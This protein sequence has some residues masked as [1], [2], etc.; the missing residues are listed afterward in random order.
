MWQDGDLLSISMASA[1]ASD[2]RVVGSSMEE[3]FLVCRPPPC[4]PV[5]DEGNEHCGWGQPMSVAE[6]GSD[7]EVEEAATD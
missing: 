5:G 7:S 3:G 6:R 1:T 2:S 4:A